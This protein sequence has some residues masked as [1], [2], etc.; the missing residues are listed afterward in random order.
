VYRWA[1]A[2]LEGRA[3]GY[4]ADIRAVYSVGG[5]YLCQGSDIRRNIRALQQVE[6]SVCHDLFLT[7]TARYCDLVL[8]VTTF[9]EREDIV[10]PGTNHLFYSRQAVAP[11]GEARDDYDIFLD[12]AGRLGFGQAYGEGRTAAQWLDRFLADSEVEDAGRFRE[13]GIYFGK[14]Q[15]RMGLA[16]FVRDPQAH[17]LST[18]SGLIEIAS[19]D[20][21]RTGFPAAPRCPDAEPAAEAEAGILRMVTPHSRYRVNSQNSNLP[22]WAALEPPV[23]EMNPADARSRAIGEGASVL[24]ENEQGRVE[25]PVRLTEGIMPGVVCLIQG[26][27]PAIRED[28]TDVGGAANMLTSTVPTEPSQGARTHSVRVRVRRA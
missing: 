26:S 15:L 18:P 9:L 8:P 19:A 5:N 14:D 17:P 4:P 1:D 23:L 12:L 28:G 22:G 6:F 2:V 20:Y 7:P 24:V 27:W 10:F 3:G 21:A 25:V 13:T 16:D 11:V